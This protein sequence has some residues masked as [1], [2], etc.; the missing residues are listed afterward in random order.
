MPRGKQG[1]KAQFSENGGMVSLFS[2]IFLFS[3]EYDM[4]LE[5][6]VF[7]ILYFHSIKQ[8]DGE[9]NGIAEA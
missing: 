7:L 3:R 5:H 8:N 9:S 1:E 4:Y 6:S 2:L